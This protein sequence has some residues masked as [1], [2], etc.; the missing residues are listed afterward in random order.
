MTKYM[1]VVVQVIKA[2]L[3]KQ[4]LAAD[5]EA[6]KERKA[7]AAAKAAAAGSQGQVRHH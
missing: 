6:E 3:K 4:I 1:Q 2:E 5:E 7:A